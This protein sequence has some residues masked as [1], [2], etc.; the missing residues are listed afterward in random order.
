MLPLLSCCLHPL[1]KSIN[2]TFNAQLA[3]LPSSLSEVLYGPSSP[4]HPSTTAGTCFLQPRGNQSRLSFQGTQVSVIDGTRSTTR[5]LSLAHRSRIETN[6][7]TCPFAGVIPFNGLNLKGC[8]TIHLTPQ[9]V[10]P[11]CDCNLAGIMTWLVR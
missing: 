10:F 5:L 9:S 1:L 4:I 3:I 2:R 6:H 11:H 7:L 8:L